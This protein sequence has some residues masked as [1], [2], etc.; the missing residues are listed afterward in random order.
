MVKKKK[1]KKTGTAISKRNSVDFKKLKSYGITK[2]I[3]VEIDEISGEDITGGKDTKPV[4][5]HWPVTAGGRT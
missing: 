1:Q 5:P 2:G 3:S 4:D